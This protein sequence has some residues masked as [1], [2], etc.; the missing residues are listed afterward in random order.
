MLG[1]Y[2]D[3][4]NNKTKKQTQLTLPNLETEPGTSNTTIWCVTSSP[5]RQLNVSNEVKRFQRNGSKH[6]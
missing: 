4:N 3:T 2:F 1:L 6:K 5:L